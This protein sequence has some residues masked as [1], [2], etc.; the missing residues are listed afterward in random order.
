MAEPITLYVITPHA[1]LELQRRGIAQEFVHRVLAAP[2]Q[3]LAARAGRD[4]L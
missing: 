2:E 1:A 3:R 4:V